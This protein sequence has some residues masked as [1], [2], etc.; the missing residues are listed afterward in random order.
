MFKE[1]MKIKIT[2]NKIWFKI[3]EVLFYQKISCAK[4][5]AKEIKCSSQK[6][7]DQLDTLR[8]LGIIKPTGRIPMKDLAEK[9]RM[10]N[11]SQYCLLTETA[12]EAME[13][14]LK[15]ENQK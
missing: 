2:E 14:M 9:D 13:E 5:I 1:V 15:E 11:F 6:A 4:E 3:C 12:R 8:K 10:G 7:R